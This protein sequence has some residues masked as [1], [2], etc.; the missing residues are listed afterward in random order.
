MANPLKGEVDFTVG[1]DTYVLCY[2]SNS[3]VEIETVAGKDIIA[4]LA[5]W[6]QSP[7][8]GPL[9][10]LLWGGMLKHR[11]GT[12]LL[13]AGELIDEIGAER[14]EELG[15]VIGRAL[16]FRLSGIAVD[17]PIAEADAA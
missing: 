15:G 14:M 8:I 12:S 16:R 7:A 5:E 1:P 17:A 10:T 9:R 4:V 13:D 2:P 11:P 6:Q 3:L